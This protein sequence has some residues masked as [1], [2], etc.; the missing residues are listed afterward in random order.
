MDG[1]EGGVGVWVDK[2]RIEGGGVD[3]WVEGRGV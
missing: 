3:R 2:K 1:S